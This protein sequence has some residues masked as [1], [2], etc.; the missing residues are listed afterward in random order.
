LT[1]SLWGQYYSFMSLSTCVA[2]VVIGDSYLQDFD[3]YARQR[4]QSYCDHHGY[5][6]RLITEPIRELNGKSLIWQ[7]FLIRELPWWRRYDQVA[8]LD[9]DILIARDAPPLPVIPH[10]RIGGVVDKLPYQMNGGV[11]I[12]HPDQQI[13]DLFEEVL[14]DQC[15]QKLITWDQASLTRVVQYRKMH[16]EIDRRFNRVVF[17]RCWSIFGTL[18]RKQWFYHCAHGKEKIPLVSLWLRMT[19]R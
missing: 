16:C 3:R 4:M 10:G 9:S 17:L 13:Y 15:E 11:M 14:A 6:L 18:L 5:D 12:Y 2:V 19:L 8:Y 1:T 7:K